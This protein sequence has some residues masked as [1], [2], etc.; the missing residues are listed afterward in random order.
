VAVQGLAAVEHHEQLLVAAR[1]GDKDCFARLIEPHISAGYRLAVSMLND[2][3]HAEDVVQEATFRAWRA[4]G[5]LSSS[6]RM[7]PW[8]LSIVANR[9]RSI[10]LTRWW[11]VVRL[12][13]LEARHSSS[14]ESADGHEDLLRALKRLSP[15]ER[16][17]V[18]LHF[19]EDMT[20]R[21][22]GDVLGIS[23]TAVRS[24]IHRAL[25]RLRVD[26]AEEE[27]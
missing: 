3:G 25:R 6:S 22:V 4:V 21:E 19:Y 7:R 18:F 26:L 20:S 17:A 12:P 13:L 27:L 1:A 15:D 10:R 9:C 5:Q 14:S 16:A 2:P 8:F 24:R 23:A 11:S